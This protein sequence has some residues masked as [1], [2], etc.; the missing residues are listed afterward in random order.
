M[1][2]SYWSA[3]YRNKAIA[4]TEHGADLIEEAVRRGVQDREALVIPYTNLAAMQREV[5]DSAAATRMQQLA[6]RAKGTVR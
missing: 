5:G 2:V 3:G 6:E 1:G 4:L